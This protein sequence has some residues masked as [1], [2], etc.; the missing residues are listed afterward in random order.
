MTTASTLVTVNTGVSDNDGTG[1]TIK[2][3]FTIVN[4]NINK[5]NDQL[6]GTAFS[7]TLKPVTFLTA[8]GDINANSGTIRASSIRGNAIYVNG[9][10]VLTSASGG[11]A[12]GTI[13]YYGIF[14]NTDPSTSTTTGVV[15]VAGGVGIQGN[16]NLGGLLN[17]AGDVTVANLSAQN[18]FTSNLNA[19]GSSALNSLFVV[20]DSTFTGTATHIGPVVFNSTATFN[21]PM[22]VNADET[23]VGNVIVDGGERVTGN[24]LIDG[25][26]TTTGNASF[27][28]MVLSSTLNVAGNITASSALQAKAIGNVAPGSGAFT[29]LNVVG[30]GTF[31]NAQPSYSTTTGALVVTGGAGIGGNLYVGGTIYASNLVSISTS[32]LV[33][34][35]PLLY[36][37]PTP[38]YPYN[39]D[40]GFFGRFVGGPANVEVHT[41][42]VRD[43]SDQVWKL[44]SNVGEP[45]GGTVDFSDPGIIYDTL[46]VGNLTTAGTIS[47]IGSG[48]TSV[49]NSALTNSAITINSG[50]GVSGGGAVSL[51]GSLTLTNSG[52]TQII[53]G[54]GIAV[55]GAT[56]NVTVSVTASP[57]YTTITVANIVHSGTSGVGDIGSGSNTFGTVYATATSAK[58]ADLAE[59]Y[60]ADSTYEPGTVLEFGGVHEV[61]IAEDGTRRVVGVVSTDPAHLMNSHCDGE[62]VVAIALAG[63]VPCK[64]RGIIAKGDMLVSAGSGFARADYNPIMGSVVGKALENFNGIEGVIEIVVGRL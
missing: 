5:L 15:T 6:N 12:G 49:P 11:W 3:A 10:P 2:D 7:S 9:S 30:R 64:V 24:V 47:G 55:S 39:Y 28:S 59:N 8:T 20:N 35:A 25:F 52:V 29:A 14:A 27:S 56:G 48:L 21:V 37:E 4:D 46:K 41:G 45:S 43:D 16:L 26:L 31:S 19:S 44:F 18:T 22:Y 32:T 57:E 60:K 36:L 51:G 63:R 38:A 62:H 34:T 61:T 1:S 13:D 53:A 33:A 54:S 50:Y 42:L 23:I 58:Y 40:L 17:V